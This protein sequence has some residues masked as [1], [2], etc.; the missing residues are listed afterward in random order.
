MGRDE[1]GEEGRGQI[2]KGLRNP[3]EDSWTLA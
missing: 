3:I 1:P 2:I